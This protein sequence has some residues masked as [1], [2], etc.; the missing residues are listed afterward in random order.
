MSNLPKYVPCYRGVSALFNR[1]TS[2]NVTS[3]I[4]ARTRFNDR[5][6][7]VYVATYHNVSINKKIAK[8]GTC[9]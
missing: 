3:D 7:P 6:R 8:N 9:N 2:A 4:C 1:E 5:A